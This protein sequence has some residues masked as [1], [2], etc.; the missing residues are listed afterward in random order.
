MSL[1][2]LPQRDRY[3]NLV[4]CG[5]CFG[6]LSLKDFNIFTPLLFLFAYKDK[7]ISAFCG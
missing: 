7:R 4:I 1:E 2:F 3:L 5:I 6:V